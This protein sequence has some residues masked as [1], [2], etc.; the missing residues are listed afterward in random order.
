MM[1]T[2]KPPDDKETSSENKVNVGKST[3][4]YE[5]WRPHTMKIGVGAA[6]SLTLYG[7]SS[8]MWDMTYN[9]MTMSPASGMYYGFVSGV[10][11]TSLTAASL[12]Y[13]R[14]ATKVDGNEILLAARKSINASEDLR[15]LMGGYIYVGELAGF[16]HTYGS[17]KMSGLLPRWKAPKIEMIFNVYCGK[18]EGIATLSASQN[19]LYGNIDFLGVD[20]LNKN[21]SRVLVEGDSSGFETHDTLNT[22]IT[23]RTT[24]DDPDIVGQK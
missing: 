22:L 9:I 14:T 11:L 8:F 7:L 21:V 1:C 17:F 18:S 3:S 4:F 5:T 19:G 20:V 15:S 6:A 2:A 24:S 16:R 12:Y 10:G 23:F 13:V